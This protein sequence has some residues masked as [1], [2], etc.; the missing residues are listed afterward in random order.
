MSTREYKYFLLLD[1]GEDLEAMRAGAALFVG[2]HDFRNFCKVLIGPHHDLNFMPRRICGPSDAAFIVSCI[3]LT[4]SQSVRF[5][6]VEH[7]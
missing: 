4:H 5:L 1:G 2:E 6:I 7:A 3:A